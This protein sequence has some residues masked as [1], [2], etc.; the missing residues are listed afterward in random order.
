MSEQEVA[1]FRALP[2]ADAAVRLRR[3]DEA[4][5]VKDLPTPPVTHFPPLLACGLSRAEASHGDA[6]RQGPPPRH[7]YAVSRTG[8]LAAIRS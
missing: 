8:P 6:S 7:V 4:A 3:F 1:A 2:Q 5:K